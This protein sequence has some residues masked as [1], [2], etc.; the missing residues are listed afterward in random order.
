MKQKYSKATIGI[1][2][3]LRN[4]SQIL[5]WIFLFL[6]VVFTASIFVWLVFT[7]LKSN[8]EIFAGVWNLPKFLHWENFIIVLTQFDFLTYFKNSL[9]VVCPSVFFLLLVSIPAAY[10]LS[11][12]KFR[13]RGPILNA[14]IL[15]IGIPSQ[16]LLVPLFFFLKDLNIVDS[17]FGLGVVYVSLSIPFTVYLLTGFFSTLPSELEEAALLDGCSRFGAFWK[18]MLPLSYPGIATATV[19]NFLFL[20]NE[21]LLAL[22]LIHSNE[23]YTLSLGLYGLQ[24]QMTYT[25]NWAGMFAGVVIMIIPVLIVYLFL[26]RRLI[27]GLTLGAVKG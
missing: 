3:F 9:V 21:F 10:A 2:S 17:F 19:F 13:G 25:A 27:S 8:K 6:W 26:A 4:L 1:N 15:G 23:K 7:S 5:A 11:R 22:V 16:V 20:W 18:I 12:F 24:T 14:F